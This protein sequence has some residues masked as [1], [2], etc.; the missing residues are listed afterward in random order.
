MRIRSA[1]V[2][3]SQHLLDL[4]NWYVANSVATFDEAPLTLEAVRAWVAQ[5]AS[6][7]YLLLIAEAEG[8]LLGYCCSQQYRVHPAFSRTV[9]TSIYVQ[10]GLARSG[11]GSALYS[12]LFPSLQRAE[13]HRAVV[14]I[15]LP[16][17]P[18]IRL[19]QKF[20]FREVGVFTEYAHKWGRAI[21]SQWMERPL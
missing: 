5:F 9:E 21:S 14:G 19:H 3:D 1:S 20:G 7:P 13:F 6:G 18:S 15:A 2:E 10:P 17:E 16:N 12:E 8:Q 11:V 4:R